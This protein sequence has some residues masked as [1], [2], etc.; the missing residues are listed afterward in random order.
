V[1]LDAKGGMISGGSWHAAGTSTTPRSTC[2]GT[3]EGLRAL[4]LTRRKRALEHVIQVTST[5]LSRVLAI[6][7]RGRDLFAAAERLDLEVWRSACASCTPHPLIH[8]E[9]AEMFAKAWPCGLGIDKRHEPV[10]TS[11]RL[12]KMT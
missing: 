2:S 12:C 8:S 6:E 5:L 9:A 10:T 7:G 4:P 1:A 11:F 3:T